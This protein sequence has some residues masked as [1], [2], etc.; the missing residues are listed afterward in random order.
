MSVSFFHDAFLISVEADKRKEDYDKYKTHLEK[1]LALEREIEDRKLALTADSEKK[2][3]QQSELKRQR[4]I[5]ELDKNSKEY[6]TL[7]DIINE[8][9]F[10][11]RKE[12]SAKYDAEIQSIKLERI[13]EEQKELA[14]HIAREPKRVG[15]RIAEGAD[16]VT[17]GIQAL[18]FIRTQDQ[19]TKTWAFGGHVNQFFMSVRLKNLPGDTPYSFIIN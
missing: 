4:E 14:E 3:Q 10:N 13:P 18:S 6:E 7:K 16:A 11:R 5:A 15:V 2:E 8:E 12:I 17:K 9:A 1:K 19:V